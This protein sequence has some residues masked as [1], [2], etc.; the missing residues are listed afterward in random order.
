MGMLLTAARS[1]CPQPQILL[2]ST[3]PNTR[4]PTRVYFTDVTSFKRPNNYKKINSYDKIDNDNND[5]IKRF[6]S[7]GLGVYPDETPHLKANV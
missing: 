4:T 5:N 6:Q 2:L 3:A 7:E 1:Y